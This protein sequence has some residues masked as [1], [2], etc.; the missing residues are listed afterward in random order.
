MPRALRAL[1]LL[2][3]LCPAPSAWAVREWYDHYL[4]ARDRL[5]PAGRCNEALAA[6]QQAVRLKPVSGLNQQTYGLD[7]V[8]EYVPYYQ[9]ALCQLRLGNNQEALE[10]LRKEEDLGAIRKSP[11][12]RELQ[13]L[14]SEGEKQQSL[15]LAKR[16]TDEVLRLIKEADEAARDGKHERALVRLAEAQAAANSL[17]NPQLQQDVAERIARL[18][19]DQKRTAEETERS[20]RLEQLLGE[21]RALLEQ[22]KGTEAKLRFDE[23]LKLEPKSTAALE[24]QRLASEHIVQSK[25]RES[26]QGRL[27]EGRALFEAQQ[28]EQALRPL[29]EAAADKGIPEAQ[30]LLAQAQ[31]MVEGLRKERDLKL[32]LDAL[33]SQGQKLMDQRRFPEAQVVLERALTL[34]AGNVLVRD[35]AGRAL[36]RTG[37]SMLERFF[38]NEPPLLEILQPEP[39]ESEI[40]APSL[41]VVGLAVDERGLA[42]VDFALDGRLVKTVRP[43][44]SG[45][46]ELPRK[47]TFSEQFPLHEGQNEIAITARDSAGLERRQVYR[48]V[49]RLRFF[50]R[51]AFYP[52]ALAGAAGLLGL[53]F[54]A[55]VARRRRAVRK[56]FNP[57]IAGAPVM[58]VEMF[59]GRQKLM[60][61]ILNVL[62]HNSLMIS[63]ERRIGKTTFLFHL[64]RA[65]EADTATEFQFFPVSIDL[66]GV[67]EESFFHALMADV[68]EALSLGPETLEALRFR[69]ES[70]RYEGRDF[71]HDLQR[72]IDELKTRTPKRV[73]LALLI[74]EADVLNEYSERIN[75]RLRS[76]F[77]KTFSE[78]LVAIM[79][80]VGVRRIWKSE[81]SPW[82]NFFDEVELQPFSREEAE[83]LIRQPVEGIFRYEP[84]AVSAILEE[85]GLKPYVIQKFCIHAVNRMIEDGRASVTLEDVRAVRE[86]VRHEERERLPELQPAAPL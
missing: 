30:L 14:R 4:E 69:T 54:A 5:I 66:Q 13:R 36:E 40:E 55:Q 44:P 21:G 74:D 7:F 12:Y 78:H 43:Q 33:L 46:G 16:A 67:P 84:E 50:E 8:N 2:A 85:S 39:A 24:G 52:A 22:G 70:E 63:G 10:L 6:L 26:L 76:I 31:R 80:G 9:M 17:Q 73:K 79:S 51:A 34:D 11:L 32:R 57:Y 25:T 1:G 83:A 29:T 15:R 77:M 71:S 37:Q 59:F 81:G 18:R 49:R 27:R 61:R 35:L 56:R 45:P 38:P 47:A 82:Y 23:A 41:S 64:R 60:A 58:D 68:V 20:Q 3:L 19:S 62:H 65:L 53:G 48:V 28:Y 72:V 86:M 75:Q 42:E